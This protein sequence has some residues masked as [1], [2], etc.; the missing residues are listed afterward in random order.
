MIINIDKAGGFMEV[1]KEIYYFVMI[2]NI[3]AKEY[4]ISIYETYK[5]LNKYKGMEF[6]SEF[7]DVEHTLNTDDVIED[8]LAICNKNGGVLK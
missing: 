7:Y 5:Y 2:L 1:K 6:L 3:I 4:S 8:V